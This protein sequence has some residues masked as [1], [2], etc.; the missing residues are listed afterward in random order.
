MYIIEEEVKSVKLVGWYGTKIARQV[1]IANKA[2]KKA[3]SRFLSA[4]NK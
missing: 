4:N 3:E 2:L 1:R